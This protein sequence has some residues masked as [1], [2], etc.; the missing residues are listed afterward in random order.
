MP[1]L[2]LLI[3][4]ALGLPGTFGIIWTIIRSGKRY[5]DEKKRLQGREPP[6]AHWL[7]AWMPFFIVVIW[8]VIEVVL[9]VSNPGGH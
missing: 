1:P 7:L 2:S 5:D 3:C 9:R 4:F 8:M 6:L